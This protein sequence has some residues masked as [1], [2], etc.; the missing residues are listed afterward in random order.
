MVTEATSARGAMEVLQHALSGQFDAMIIDAQMPETDGLQLL[1]MI[2]DKPEF[3]G[4]PVLMTSSA[5]DAAPV[6]HNSND[7]TTVW[8]TRP[9]RRMQLQA[10]LTSLLSYQFATEWAS[11]TIRKNLRA[12]AAA[13]PERKQPRAR[14]VLLV[15][16]NPVNQE[17]ALAVLQDLGIEA[18]SAWSGE[19]ALEKLMADR[20]DVVLMDCQM[21]KLDGY[22][23]TSRF[24]DWETE[25][26]RPRTPIVALTANALSGDAE[27]CYAAGMDRHLSKPFTSDA[28]LQ[29]L[30]SCFG[31]AAPAVALGCHSRRQGG[32]CHPRPGCAGADPCAA[33]SG[34][35]QPAGQGAGTVL[36]QLRRRSSIHCAPPPKPRTPRGCARRRTRLSRAAP[37]SA[38]SPLRN[39]ARTWKP[40]PPPAG[41]TKPVCCSM[42]CSPATHACCR[43]SPR[44]TWRPEV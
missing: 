44:K 23:T 35:P 16:D 12:L 25:Q 36:I 40:L 27:K 4:I 18:V 15:E 41:S 22:A 6:A 37:M 43:R 9:M 29:V 31:E 33:P 10:C 20:F 7:G 11:E 17:V 14:R 24:R 8:L 1:A 32:R 19:E 5:D 21:P 39:S 34:R 2:R 26:Q 28:L 38:R 30:E 42:S 13:K 3:R